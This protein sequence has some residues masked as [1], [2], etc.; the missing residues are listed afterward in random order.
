MA[1]HRLRLQGHRLRLQGHRLRWQGIQ[2]GAWTRSGPHPADRLFA[3]HLADARRHLVYESYIP[4]H[5]FFCSGTARR[6]SSPGGGEGYVILPAI[7]SHG[8]RWHARACDGLRWQAMAGDGRRWQAT[9]A[10]FQPTLASANTAARVLRRWP[11]IACDGQ[12][13]HAT[14]NHRTALHSALMH[15]RKFGHWTIAVVAHTTCPNAPGA[16]SKL[17]IQAQESR[18]RVEKDESFVMGRLWTWING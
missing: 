16:I 15:V 8:L 17:S 13:L 14:V 11:E 9:S 5:E 10:E 3:R 4:R 6:S 7:A 12:R 18:R 2:L 1:G